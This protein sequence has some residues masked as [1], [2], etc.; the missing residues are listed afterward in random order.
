V[1]K[2]KRTKRRR[3]ASTGNGAQ[4]TTGRTAG[5]MEGGSTETS[6]HPG[7]RGSPS[8]STGSRTVRPGGA[9]STRS[10]PTRRTE[11]RRGDRRTAGGRTHAVAGATHPPVGVSLARGLSI[12]GGSP[13]LLGSAAVAAL[14]LWI[15]FQ[16]S[17]VV[18]VAS[19]GFMAQLESLPG[20]HSFVD[21]QFILASGGGVTGAAA[22]AFG[23]GLLAFRGMLLSLW[24]TLV[25]DSLRHRA[26]GG[27]RVRLGASVR[28]AIR[29][30]P[31]MIVVEAGFLVLSLGSLAVVLSFFGASLGILAVLAG[32]MP[33]LYFFVFVPVVLAAEDRSLR[34][35]VRL[36]IRAARLP[37]PRHM[38]L[39]IGYLSVAILVLASTPTA[40]VAT[41]TPS[42]TVWIFVLFA[43]FLH[44]A[45]LAAYV[46]RW[47]V[48]REVVLAASAEPPEP[49]PA[50]EHEPA[51]PPRGPDA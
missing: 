13:A 48:V 49:G 18:L 50:P 30:T 33:G 8:G 32:L 11:H 7:S 3:P 51:T 45:V 37:G 14:L 6:P 1:A 29:R 16:A 25:L 15:G 27:P 5:P 24:T 41:A 34:T 4:A 42:L 17:G 46:F 10:A 12:V 23:V 2:K 36:A 35:S 19:P 47:L 38:L 22:L 43:G 9:R 40:R 21:V 44:L 28:R 31:S 20:L 39:T 26:A